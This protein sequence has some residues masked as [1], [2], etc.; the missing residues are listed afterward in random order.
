MIS[1]SQWT[2]PLVFGILSAKTGL[3][4]LFLLVGGSLVSGSW[5]AKKRLPGSK[6]NGE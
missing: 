2:M 1:T 4:P 5:F 6:Q 3:L